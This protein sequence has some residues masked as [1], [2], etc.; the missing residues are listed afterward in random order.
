MTL[1]QERCWNRWALIRRLDVQCRHAAEWHAHW[2]CH[3][4]AVAR[5]MSML[6]AGALAHLLS[7]AQMP[8]PTAALQPS[9]QLNGSTSQPCALLILPLHVPCLQL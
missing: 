1:A 2:D 4:Q 5:I 6:E 8:A 3:E 9:P 7:L